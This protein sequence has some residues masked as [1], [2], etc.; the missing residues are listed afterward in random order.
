MGT[1]QIDGLMHIGEKMVGISKRYKWKTSK[2]PGVR[3]REHPERKHGVRSD[4][5]FV[6]RFQAQGRRRE[7]ALGWASE[8]WTEHKAA[9]ELA[10]LKEAS[11]MGKGPSS[12]AEKRSWSRRSA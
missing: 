11:K 9:I 12:L 4:R 2:F 1:K 10:K 7:E 8:G 5:Y 3:Y 6:I